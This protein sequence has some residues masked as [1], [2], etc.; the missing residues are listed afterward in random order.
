[1]QLSYRGIK[2]NTRSPK[3]ATAEGNI[4]GRYRGLILR[5]RVV[6]RN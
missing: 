6:K 2:Y 4:I 1:M 3:I 5:T